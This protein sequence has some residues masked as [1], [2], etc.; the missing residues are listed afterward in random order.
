MVGIF[1]FTDAKQSL[2]SDPYM[3]PNSVKNFFIYSTKL[4]INNCHIHNNK[5]ISASYIWYLAKITNTFNDQRIISTVT[6]SKT[7]KKSNN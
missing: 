2:L 3:S 4:F 7:W 5:P 1:T 6:D